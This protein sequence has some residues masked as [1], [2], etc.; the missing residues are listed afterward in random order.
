MIFFFQTFRAQ[1][2]I[3]LFSENKKKKITMG[4]QN[5]KAIKYEK[6]KAVASI[7]WKTI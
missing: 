6:T 7:N 1:K 5:L 3:F 2:I 4:K